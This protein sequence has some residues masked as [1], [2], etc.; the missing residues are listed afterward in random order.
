MKAG[1]LRL[2]YDQE[3]LPFHDMASMSCV[4]PWDSKM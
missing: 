4:I 1:N 3:W 2:T